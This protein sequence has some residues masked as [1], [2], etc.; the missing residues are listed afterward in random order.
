MI[1]KSKERRREIF[2]TS[3]TYKSYMPPSRKQ[4]IAITKQVVTLVHILELLVINT[5]MRQ[6]TRM[7]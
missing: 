5:I 7:S 1:M 2:Y 4:A 6:R 3:R